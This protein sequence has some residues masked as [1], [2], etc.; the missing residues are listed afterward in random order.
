VY[1]NLLKLEHSSMTG[2]PGAD[3]FKCGKR[4]NAISFSFL[5]LFQRLVT[6]NINQ[7]AAKNIDV[8][9]VC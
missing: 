6:F 4:T 2:G 8:T 5:L 3:K 9:N 7:L 1:T